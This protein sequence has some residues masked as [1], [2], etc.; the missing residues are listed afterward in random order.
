MS[1]DLNMFDFFFTLLAAS[2]ISTKRKYSRWSNKDT[3]TVVRYFKKWID[4]KTQPG[5][6]MEKTV[7]L[8]IVYHWFESTVYVN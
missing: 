7:L 1:L 6:Y 8:V 4:E 3:S 5:M 2:N